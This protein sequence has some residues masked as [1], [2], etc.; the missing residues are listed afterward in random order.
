VTTAT[1]A[2]TTTATAAAASVTEKALK[3]LV[4]KLLHAML[5]G[6]ELGEAGELLVELFGVH[7][8]YGVA[9]SPNRKRAPHAPPSQLVARRAEVG[10]ELIRREGGGKG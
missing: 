10:D 8:G 4:Q 5:A 9:L 3:S 6:F 7:F 2:T 1:P